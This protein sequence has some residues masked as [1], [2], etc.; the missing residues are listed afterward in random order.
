MALKEVMQDMN[1]NRCDEFIRAT[2]Y[3]YPYP[4]T[5]TLLL[6]IIHLIRQ[7]LI[8]TN[9]KLRN[10]NDKT[11]LQMIPEEDRVRFLEEVMQDININGIKRDNE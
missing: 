9:C 6:M 2:T 3:M 8:D 1:I 5:T 4:L 7:G 10:D 11:L